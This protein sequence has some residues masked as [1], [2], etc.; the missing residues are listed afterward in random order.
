M[1]NI[2][3][4]IIGAGF[5]GPMHTEALKRL[6]VQVVGILGVD[7]A[8]SRKTRAALGLTK[9]HNDLAEL[10]ADD[11][12]VDKVQRDNMNETGSLQVMW[13]TGHP[14]GAWAH[15]AGPALSD[16]ARSDTPSGSNARLLVAGQ[17]FAYDGFYAWP[18]EDGTTKT[19]SVEEMA[20]I[21]ETGAEYMSTPQEDLKLISSPK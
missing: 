10:L 9:A 15:D 4:A 3:A 8:K 2:K 21:T 12:L 17:T 19:S 13:R 11:W 16:A 14:V 5:M 1:K 20:V 6:G 18:R 7:E